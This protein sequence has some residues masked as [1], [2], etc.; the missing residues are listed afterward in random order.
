MNT[1]MKTT[2]LKIKL[3]RASRG[4]VHTLSEVIIL[5][6]SSLKQDDHGLS[7]AKQKSHY[8]IIRNATKK[9]EPIL[10]CSQEQ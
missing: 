3:N 10:D 9:I 7:K 1:A 6:T 4:I 5:V 2:R 8:F